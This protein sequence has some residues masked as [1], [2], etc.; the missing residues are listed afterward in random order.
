MRR[1]LRVMSSRPTLGTEFTLKRGGEEGKGNT[2]GKDQKAEMTKM[3]EK[4]EKL[5]RRTG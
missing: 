1:N 3:I 5:N 4:N 2:T